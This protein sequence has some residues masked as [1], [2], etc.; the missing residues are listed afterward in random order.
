MTRTAEIHDDRVIKDYGLVIRIPNPF[1]LDRNNAS[2]T[3]CIFAGGH[4]YGTHGAAKWFTRT[5][6]YTDHA[7]ENQQHG[8]VALIEFKVDDGVPD[9]GRIVKIYQFT[10]EDFQWDLTPSGGFRIEEVA[11]EREL[12]SK[13]GDGADCEDAIVVNSNFAAVIDGATS[14]SS[15]TW[16]RKTGGQMAADSISE[17]IQSQ[18]LPDA[19]AHE[20]VLKMTAAIA[21]VYQAKNQFERMN[22]NPVDRASASVVILSRERKQIWMVGDCQ[23]MILM[24]G[25][26]CRRI[27]NDKA[28]DRINAEA[29]A[30][31]LASEIAQGKNT[32]ELQE[33][34]TG[35]QFIKELLRRQ[36]DFQ[37]LP[38]DK[39]NRL[40]SYVYWVIDGF[41]VPKDAIRVVD[42]PSNATGVVL[43]S[44]GYPMLFPTLH[45]TERFRQTILAE[46]SL[47]MRGRYKST[48]GVRKG[49][50][51]YDDRAYVRIAI[52]DK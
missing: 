40:K 26:E 31:Y 37:N 28:V 14:Q 29:R 32:L 3:V 49:N 23:C 10:T 17:V 30:L 27:T 8:V 45:D 33:D 48:K 50:V 41:E 44:D 6:A 4:T 19:D 7:L 46:D 20:A 2:G 22:E 36:R 39:E 52:I 25:G 51:S 11:G 1:S 21:E 13:T 43:A 34:D 9:V 35:R 18:L 16:D 47:L 42:L 12:E 38:I 5:Y 15:I 24:R